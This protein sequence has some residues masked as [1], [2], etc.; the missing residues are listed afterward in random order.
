MK[1]HMTPMGQDTQG[2]CAPRLKAYIPLPLEKIKSSWLSS[3]TSSVVHQQALSSGLPPLITGQWTL[4]KVITNK[5]IPH[6]LF[7]CLFKQN[8]DSGLPTPWVA[9]GC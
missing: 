7:A 6:I 3:H 2:L 9:E 1:S 4:P 5:D 8:A